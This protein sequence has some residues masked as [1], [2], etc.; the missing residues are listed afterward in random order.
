MGAAVHFWL[1]V[2]AF[3]G[4]GAYAATAAPLE[5]LSMASRQRARPRSRP[6]GLTTAS[7]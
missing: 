1:A 5:T 2:T 6:D 3:A 7:T 4:D